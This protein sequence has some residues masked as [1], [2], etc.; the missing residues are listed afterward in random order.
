M[1]N[2]FEIAVRE[3]YRF[4]TN[5]GLITTEQLWTLP[6]TSRSGVSLESI[7]QV[8]YTEL[9]ESEKVSGFSLGD[10]TKT[11]SSN[12]QELKTKMEIIQHI[13]KVR[14]EEKAN[15]KKVADNKLRIAQ[16]KDLLL[17][18][19]NEE[20]LALSKE[21]LLEELKKLQDSQ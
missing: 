4:N 12:I 6:L 19:E 9:Q 7:G 15:R 13:A 3:A 5:K 16:L 21:D 2:I 11:T 10:A 20:A 1:M 18:K 14:Q 8:I 17:K